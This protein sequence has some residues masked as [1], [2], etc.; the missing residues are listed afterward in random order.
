MWAPAVRCRYLWRPRHRLDEW[1]RRALA[2]FEHRAPPTSLH[3]DHHFNCHVE[4]QQVYYLDMST[5]EESRRGHLLCRSRIRCRCHHYDCLSV[6]SIHHETSHYLKSKKSF[7]FS[8]HRRRSLVD[9]HSCQGL[10]QYLINNTCHR[11]YPRTCRSR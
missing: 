8:Y 7:Y 11:L 1:M 9:S 6:A 3:Q 4:E 10:H 5:K 2:K